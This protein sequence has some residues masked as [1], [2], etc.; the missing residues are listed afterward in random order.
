VAWVRERTISTERP[1]LVGEVNVNFL[2]IGG[3]TWSAWRIPT[4]VFSISR[5]EALLF[6]QVAPQ[7][8]S[9]GR[10]DPVPDPLLYIYWTFPS[11]MSQKE[12]FT[13]FETHFT[14]N[15]ELSR[16]LYIRLHLICSMKL[17]RTE[18]Y[19]YTLQLSSFNFSDTKQPLYVPPPQSLYKQTRRFLFFAQPLVSLWISFYLSDS[20]DI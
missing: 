12:Y 13:N 11:K 18:L 15:C 5:Q 19:Q 14:F 1:L 3:A 20:S 9:R 4:A 17:F 2:R 7:L 10:V 8:Y 6:Y 16:K